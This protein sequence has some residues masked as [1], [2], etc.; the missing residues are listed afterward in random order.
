MNGDMKEVFMNGGL[1]FVLGVLTGIAIV[2]G[3][4]WA[5]CVLYKSFGSNN[6]FTK[7]GP[8]KEDREME[9]VIPELKAIIPEVVDEEET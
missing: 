8:T 4:A 3:T 6:P 7:K 9:E 1:I 5:L 2:Y